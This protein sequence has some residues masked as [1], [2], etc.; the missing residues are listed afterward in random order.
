MNAVEW[1]EKMWLNAR[2][3]YQFYILFVAVSYSMFFFVKKTTVDRSRN[4]ILNEKSIRTFSTKNRI[5]L[6]IPARKISEVIGTHATGDIY[7]NFD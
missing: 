2:T 1:N 5:L 4:N 6:T 3:Y 7:R